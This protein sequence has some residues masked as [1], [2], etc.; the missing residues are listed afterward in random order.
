MA[1][2]NDD[3]IKVTMFENGVPVGYNLSYNKYNIYLNREINIEPFKRTTS[4]TLTRQG[5]TSVRFDEGPDLRTASFIG[6]CSGLSF[7][8][9]GMIS[10]YT[11][12]LTYIFQ[13]NSKII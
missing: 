7:G 5:L 2:K 8:I 4:I 13:E 3:T 10:I 1:N 9:A 6:I 12:Y 11:I